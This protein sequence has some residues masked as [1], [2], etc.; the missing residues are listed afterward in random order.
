MIFLSFGVM[1]SKS[2]E[3]KYSDG[4]RVAKAYKASSFRFL[5]AFSARIY[6]EW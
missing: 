1:E 6:Y 2:N 3:V 5:Y 4:M